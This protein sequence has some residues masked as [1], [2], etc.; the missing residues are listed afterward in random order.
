MGL[1]CALPFIILCCLSHVLFL[2]TYLFLFILQFALL[3]MESLYLNVCSNNNNNNHNNNNNNNHRHHH[4]G[5]PDHSHLSATNNCRSIYLPLI[6]QSL[7]LQERAVQP[8]VLAD[9][10][11]DKV[12]STSR[13][14]SAP[15]LLQ[16][17]HYLQNG[18][19]F[20]PTPLINIT[21]SEQTGAVPPQASS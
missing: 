20:A 14:T 17:R 11:I 19:D 6:F 10:Y 5:L 12:V 2:V 8:P 18:I 7:G 4:H 16:R 21:G 3:R 15:L 1:C 13:L 9:S